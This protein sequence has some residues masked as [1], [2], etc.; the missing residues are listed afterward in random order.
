[1]DETCRRIFGSEVADRAGPG[2]TLDGTPS[3]V[4]ARS[5]HPGFVPRFVCRDRGFAD[6]FNHARFWYNGG[7]RF[8]SPLQ[9]SLY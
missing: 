4:C 5:G 6:K 2:W 7:V 3:A 1:M 8:T 9:P